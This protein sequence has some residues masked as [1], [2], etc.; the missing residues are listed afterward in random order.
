MYSKA[1]RHLQRAYELTEALMHSESTSSQQNKNSFGG[2]VSEL[3]EKGL[4]KGREEKKQTTTDLTALR[5]WLKKIHA[6]SNK[7]EERGVSEEII[8]ELK[9]KLDDAVSSFN[10]QRDDLPEEHGKPPRIA[11]ERTA[12]AVP[13]ADYSTIGFDEW[14]ETYWKKMH[15]KTRPPVPTILA[16]LKRK[17][18]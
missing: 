13:I 10:K 14:T 6:I 1:E 5:A 7:I 3:T 12:N 2:L 15:E 9:R 16:R 11:L 8:K 18:S 4:L 17:R